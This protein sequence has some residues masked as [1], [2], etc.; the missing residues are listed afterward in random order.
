MKRFLA[1]FPVLVTVTPA[2]A[3]EP[4]DRNGDG[5][6]T[7]DEIQRVLPQISTDTY[8]WMDSDGDSLLDYEELEAARKAGTLPDAGSTRATVSGSP[9]PEAVS[10]LRLR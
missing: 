4:L 5:W 9:R 10:F 7:F 8:I 2:F 3:G 6:V 1:L